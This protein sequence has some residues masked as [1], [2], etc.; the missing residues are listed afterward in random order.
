MMVKMNHKLMVGALVLIEAKRMAELLLFVAVR[1][2]LE[3][4]HQ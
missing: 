2:F 1:A 4:Y 3:V